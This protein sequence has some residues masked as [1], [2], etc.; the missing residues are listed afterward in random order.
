MCEVSE[1]NFDECVHYNL[2]EL[3]SFQP[4]LYCDIPEID[5]DLIISLGA[6]DKNQQILF[7]KDIVR[8]DF[9]NYEEYQLGEDHPYITHYGI[10]TL[11]VN[12]F[13][14]G[15]LI[16]NIAPGKYPDNP[17][18][19]SMGMY[20]SWDELE[21]IGNV[22]ETDFYKCGHCDNIEFAN[23]PDIIGNCSVCGKLNLTHIDLLKHKYDDNI[24]GED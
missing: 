1:I 12:S 22:Y 18:Y 19:D 3:K 7:N 8:Y 11:E 24:L 9:L 14:N 15:F 21:K 2:I 6:K 20:F 4:G 13:E 10:V 5:I 17:F 23:Q 16:T